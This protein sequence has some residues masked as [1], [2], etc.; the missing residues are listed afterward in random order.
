[1]RALTSPPIPPLWRVGQTSAVSIKLSGLLAQLVRAPSLAVQA[2]QGYE[3]NPPRI[4]F[5]FPMY[6]YVFV[7]ILNGKKVNL[8]GLVAQLVKVPSY[9]IKGQGSWV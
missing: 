7:G 2:M 9:E 1:M 3:F 6:L 5:H 4:F 8:S